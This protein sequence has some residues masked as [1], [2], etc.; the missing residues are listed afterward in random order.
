MFLL[1]TATQQALGDRVTTHFPGEEVEEE[2]GSA[3]CF[4]LAARG[5]GGRGE[6]LTLVS[7]AAAPLPAYSPGKDGRSGG[8]GAQEDRGL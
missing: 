1:A 3:L 6:R 5:G 4:L 2:G 7:S 8:G